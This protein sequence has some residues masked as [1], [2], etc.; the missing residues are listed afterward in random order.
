[1]KIAL[2]PKTVWSPAGAGDVAV[3]QLEVRVASYAL[4]VGA[5]AYYDLQRRTETPIA[6]T[7]AVLDVQGNVVTPAI[8]AHIDVVEASFGLSGNV[9]LLPAQF[10]AWGLDDTYFARSIAANLGLTPA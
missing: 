3:N 4:G 5:T 2:L 10:A 8:P 9:A 1:M 7:A 6:A